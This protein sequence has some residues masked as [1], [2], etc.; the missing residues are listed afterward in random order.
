MDKKEITAAQTEEKAQVEERDFTEEQNKAQT[1]M[2]EN[3]FISG[4]IAAA[5]FR[6]D[7][8]YRNYPERDTVFCIR[9][10]GAGRRGIQQM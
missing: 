10:P 3:D 9:Y 2:F 5:G 1:R 8:T 7:E 6:T 4:L